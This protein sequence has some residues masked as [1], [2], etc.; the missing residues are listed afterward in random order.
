[1]W[2]ECAA[3]SVIPLFGADLHWLV[4]GIARYPGSA[5][6]GQGRFPET[7]G[8]QGRPEAGVADP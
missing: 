4:S 2:S 3:C 5:V 7:S 8:G 1:M 6:L